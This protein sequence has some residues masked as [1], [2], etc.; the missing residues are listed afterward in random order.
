MDLKKFGGLG[1]GYEDREVDLQEEAVQKAG[2]R[3]VVATA[4][5]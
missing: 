5:K 3:A 4:V 2:P 1:T